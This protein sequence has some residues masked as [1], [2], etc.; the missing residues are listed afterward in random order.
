MFSGG[1]YCSFIWETRKNI[2][3]NLSW[4]RN[5]PD[6][7]LSWPQS[8]LVLICLQSN[9][10]GAKSFW[11]HIFLMPNCSGA[12]LSG[13]KLSGCQIVLV[14]N[15]SGAK[16]SWCQIIWG[17]N[18]MVP[19]CLVTNCPGAKL[20]WCQIVW[21][22]IVMVPNWL[23]A[24]LSSTK[25][26]CCQIVWCQI[27]LVP[28][29]ACKA[30]FSVHYFFSLTFCIFIFKSALEWSKITKYPSF[31]WYNCTKYVCPLLGY[32]GLCQ[33]LLI[34]WAFFS[35]KQPFRP[36]GRTKNC[37]HW[38]KWS[39]TLPSTICVLA[40]LISNIFIPFW[41]ILI[42]AWAQCHCQWG[43]NGCF[44]VKRPI[45]WGVP[46]K[47]LNGPK[48]GKHAW[49]HCFMSREGV[50]CCLTILGLL[51]GVYAIFSQWPFLDSTNGNFWTPAA[52]TECLEKP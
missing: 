49:Y 51:R 27:S 28:F 3:A 45:S 38:I 14:P 36:S 34:R 25:L 47:G 1:F 23:G 42:S 5:F 44:G 39:K 30:N 50:W 7:K 37:P 52:M 43:Y 8:F 40:T 18:V 35:L 4:C 46:E 19:N 31:T 11:C 32:L 41:A 6:T 2:C 12:I 26:S 21:C 10:A 15:C 20:S 16:L 9:R 17:Q 22:Y 13:S 48:V 33:V 29:V 24:K